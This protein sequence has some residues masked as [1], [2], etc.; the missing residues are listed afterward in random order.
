MGNWIGSKKKYE[1]VGSTAY[2]WSTESIDAKYASIFALHA[3]N[4]YMLVHTFLKQDAVPVR[5]IKD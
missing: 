4:A 1:D 2:Y 5:C 3:T